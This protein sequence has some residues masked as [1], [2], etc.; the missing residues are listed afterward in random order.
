MYIVLLSRGRNQLCVSPLF[1]NHFAVH[2]QTD[3]AIVIPPPLAQNS[4]T[5]PGLGPLPCAI[6]SSRAMTTQGEPVY[7]HLSMTQCV[8]AMGCWRRSII[9]SMVRRFSCV[10]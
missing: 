1:S 8:F 5:S 6:A 4:M 9:N 3:V 7:P 10:K 2:F